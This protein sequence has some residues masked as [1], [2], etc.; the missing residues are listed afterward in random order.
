MT[1]RHFSA[2]GKIRIVLDGLRGDESIAELGRKE[3][4]AQTYVTSGR[5]SSLRAVSAG[6]G[7]VILPQPP[8]PMRSRCGPRGQPAEGMRCRRHTQE[9]SAQK[10]VIAIGRTTHEVFASEKFEVIAIV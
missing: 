4:I 3:G 8:P 6:W 2:E 1:R 7:G 9:P 10:S 5:R